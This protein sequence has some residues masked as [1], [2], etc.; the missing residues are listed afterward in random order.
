M[1]DRQLETKGAI[2]LEPN[3]HPAPVTLTLTLLDTVLVETGEF[4]K[5]E[6]LANYLIG[7]NKID[8][9]TKTLPFTVLVTLAYCL[10]FQIAG[11]LSYFGSTALNVP[12]WGSGFIGCGLGIVAMTAIQKQPSLIGHRVALLA[13]LSTI[14]PLLPILMSVLRN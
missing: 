3:S 12:F 1:A 13:V 4:K 14:V 5:L 10:I 2:A 7:N 8:D 11:Y 6:P 9:R